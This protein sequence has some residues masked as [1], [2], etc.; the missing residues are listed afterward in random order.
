MDGWSEAV[1]LL[2]ERF[3]KDVTERK[4]VGVEE[5]RLRCGQRPTVLTDG[6]EKAFSSQ[7]VTAD[8]LHCV[9]EKATGASMHTVSSALRDGFLSCRGLRIGVCGSVIPEGSGAVYQT[10][11]SLAIRIPR[12]FPGLCGR[13]IAQLYPLCFRSTL[14]I[15]PPGGGKTTALR[16]MIRLLSIQGFRL[17]VV[18]ERN[19]LSASQD[20]MAQFDLG[21]HTDLLIGLKKAEASMILLR[22]MN[23]QILAVDEISTPQDIDA[24][25]QITGC[26]VGLLATAHAASRD[27]LCQRPLYRRI[28]ENGIFTNLIT[29]EQTGSRRSYRAERLDV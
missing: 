9:L 1:N 23:P 3:Q 17:S 27:E 12:E 15:S 20:G 5:L 18:D 19:E 14:L 4:G 16:D 10:V 22:A 26:G 6:E 25:E 29:I 21:P 2:P 13:L 8:D 24:V 7:T 11:S 28:L